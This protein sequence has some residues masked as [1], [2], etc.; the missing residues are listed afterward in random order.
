[1]ANI[2]NYAIKFLQQLKQKYKAG[3]KTA[4]LTST[5]HRIRFLNAKTVQIPYI[6]VQGY[7]DHGRSG[8]FNRQ[9]LE[10]RYFTK[11]LEHDRDVEFF[12]DTMDVDETNLALSA[13]NITN[14][15]EDEQAIPE[16][17]AYR[18][19]KLYAEHIA[20]GGIVDSTV[21]TA[22][23]ALTLFDDYMQ[24]MDDD[25]VPEEGR[26]LYATPKVFKLLKQAEQI[27]RTMLVTSNS[28]AIDRSVRSLDDVSL[29]KVP[30]ARMKTAY[31][32]SDGFKP[33]AG[34][35]QM[36]MVLVHPRSVLAVDKHAYIKLWAPGEHTQGDGWLYQ[37][38]KYGDLFIIDTRKEGVI[39]NAD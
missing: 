2:V 8:G 6:I 39:I 1:M 10:N 16:T 24:K 20:L 33:A 30:P 36:N 28:G 14:T 23:N 25:E 26:I 7:K 5:D 3:L 17:D 9:D 4:G 22:I 37:N 31:D 11:T 27:T 18:M 19:S 35:R 12:V 15:F 34:A 29:V 38:R 13:A 21:I 32:F